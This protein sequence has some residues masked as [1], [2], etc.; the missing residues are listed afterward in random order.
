[1]VAATKQPDIIHFKQDFC[2]Q[3][4]SHAAE[5]ICN[6][7]KL[8]RAMQMSMTQQWDFNPIGNVKENSNILESD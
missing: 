2:K 1:M 8:S 3:R 6:Q 4:V 7:T 5:T